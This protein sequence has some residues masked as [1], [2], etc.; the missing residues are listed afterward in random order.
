MADPRGRRRAG[1]AQPVGRPAYSGWE[2]AAVPPDRL[3]AWLRTST[4]CCA[5]TGSTAFRTATSATAA[6]TCGSTSTSPAVRGVPRVPGRLRRTAA[7]ARRLAVG[8]ARRRPGAVGAVAADVRRHVA[9]PLRRGQARS[10]TRQAAEPRRAGRP[11]AVRRRPATGCA[12]SSSAGPLARGGAPV[13]G[14]GEVRG[15][16]SRRRDVP[17]VR[18][19]PAG[20]GLDP[21]RA[22]VLQEAVT[23]GLPGGLADPA[24]HE[25]LDL[26]CP[27]RAARP[28]ARPASTSRSTSPRCSTRPTPASD[29]RGPTTRWGRCRGGPGW[30][31]RGARPAT[32]PARRP[33]ASLAKAMAGV[34]Q[35]RSLP[36]LAAPT[37]QEG[38]GQRSRDARRATSSTTGGAAVSRRAARAPRDWRWATPTCGCGRTR[39]PST[40]GPGP[41]WPR[42]PTSRAPG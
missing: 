14:R 9:R 12:R 41:G 39:S 20:E 31:R 28:T 26:A 35:R 11:A 30:A 4:R 8:R 33:A 18:R 24:V 13:H 36:G 27:A 29:G 25:A 40:S 10:A 17:V 19:D 21:G 16:G 7:R 42:S 34:D 3:G 15:T 1:R 38:G 2:D 22:R 37:F 5:S 23:G 32:S 6:C